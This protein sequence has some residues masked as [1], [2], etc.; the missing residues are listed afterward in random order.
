MSKI[1]KECGYS[2]KM[3]KDVAG[4]FAIEIILWLCFLLPGVIYSV[5]RQTKRREICP[6]CKSLNLIPIDSPAGQKLLKEF[7][8]K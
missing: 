6:K 1:C 8:I 2:G 4:S 7:E 5:W 3:K